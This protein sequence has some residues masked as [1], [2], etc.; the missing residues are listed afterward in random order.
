[1][2]VS[3]GWLFLVM[4]ATG[5]PAGEGLMMGSPFFWAGELSFE[6]CSKRWGGVRHAEAAVVWTI[7]YGLTAVVLLLATLGTFDRCLGRVP[8]GTVL[9]HSRPPIE[10]AL[11]ELEELVEE[12]FEVA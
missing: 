4:T 8:A 12:P 10:P 7:A 9:P 2:L 6:L 1:V 3:V 5:G 11:D